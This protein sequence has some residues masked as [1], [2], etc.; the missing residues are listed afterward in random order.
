[1]PYAPAALPGPPAVAGACEVEVCR[2]RAGWRPR[3]RRHAGHGRRT[4]DARAAADLEDDVLGVGGRAVAGRELVGPAGQ[5][6]RAL[7]G[8]RDELGGLAEA[9]VEVVGQL[10]VAAVLDQRLELRAR[11]A[12]GHVEVAG[13]PSTPSTSRWTSFDQPMC[14]GNWPLVI[15]LWLITVSAAMCPTSAF[16]KRGA[17]LHQR[18]DV[19]HSVALDRVRARLVEHDDQHARGPIRDGGRPA[20]RGRDQHREHGQT[21]KRTGPSSAD[22]SLRPPPPSGAY[23]CCFYLTRSGRVKPDWGLS[24]RRDIARAPE[25]WNGSRAG[26]LPAAP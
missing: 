17:L 25:A 20:L 2:R 21:R 11:H 12:R 8:D 23:P 4:V 5:T 14:F 10:P 16:G 19:L 6:A 7:L 9:V 15:T 1:M 13:V 3:A 22:P 18:L 24:P 26:G